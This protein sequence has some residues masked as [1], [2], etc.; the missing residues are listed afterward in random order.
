L[1]DAS[2]IAKSG[3]SADGPA[4]TLSAVQRGRQSTWQAVIVRSEGVVDERARV[5]YAVARITDPYQLHDSSTNQTPLP[6]GSFVSAQ[7]AGS[8]I[9]SAIRLPRST[10]RRR[11]EVIFVDEDNRLRVE[12][13]QLIRTDAEFAYISTDSFVGK[14]LSLSAIESPVNGAK[15]RTTDDPPPMTDDEESV[16]DTSDSGD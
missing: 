13:V 12:T 15:V 10:L 6:M 14:R 2:E 11:N 4:V 7:I 16:A 5:T 3:K 1:P 9:D 8:T